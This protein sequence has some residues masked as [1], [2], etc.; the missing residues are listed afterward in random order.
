MDSNNEILLRVAVC[1]RLI[2]KKNK[3]IS[4]ANKE[5]GIEDLTIV[6]AL[7]QLEAA[8]GVSYPIVQ[9]LSVGERD[10]HI[11]TVIRVIEGMGVTPGVFFT[12]YDKVTKA[13]IQAAVKE[14]EES[15]KAAGKK[16]IS[17]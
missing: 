16:R 8:S 6:D 9:K 3:T 15:R 1:I 10:A 7:R 4:R 12:M 14:I 5:K 13:Q 17:K 2:L 11:T